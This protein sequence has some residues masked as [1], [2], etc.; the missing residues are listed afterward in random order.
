MLSVTNKPFIL[1]VIMLSVVVPCLY[2]KLY[3]VPN[4]VCMHTFQLFYKDESIDINCWN[5]RP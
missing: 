1:S 4:F 2:L 3:M 5:F